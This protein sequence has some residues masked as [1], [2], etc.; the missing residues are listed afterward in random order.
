ML[1][2]PRADIPDAVLL[3]DFSTDGTQQYWRGHKAFDV[4]A[5]LRSGEVK[6]GIASRF[7]SALLY[8]RY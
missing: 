7:L 4:A 6:R 5:Y 3:P 2:P 8:S 1:V